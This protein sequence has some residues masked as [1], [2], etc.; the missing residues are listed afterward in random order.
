MELGPA[1][2]TVLSRQKGPS[3]HRVHCVTKRTVKRPSRYSF[4]GDP[5]TVADRED[6]A[7]FSVSDGDQIYLVTLK[8]D[9]ISELQEGKSYIIYNATVKKDH[10]V[11]EM[12]LGNETRVFKTA[13]LQL[14]EESIHLMK[15]CV[16][17]SSERAAL[18][19]PGLYQKKGYITLTGEVDSLSPVQQTEGDIPVRDVEIKEDGV[20]K[21]VSLQ[22]EAATVPLQPGQMIKITHVKSNAQENKFTSSEFTVVS[23]PEQPGRQTFKVTSVSDQ[24]GCIS[25]QLREEERFIFTDF[26]QY[27][28]IVHHE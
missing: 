28:G 12:I 23:C 10:P 6:V 14:D 21:K 13:P 1:S 2:Y 19:D 8:G 26:I 9:Q 17:P 15:E 16:D 18:N 7:L 20:K 4:T 22:K 3:V 27:L 25:W 5:V 11:S 24:A